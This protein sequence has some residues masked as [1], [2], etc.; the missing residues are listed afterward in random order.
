MAEIK[1]TLDLVM[2]K[3]RHLSFSE[4]E[5]QEQHSH[6]FAKRIK[7]LIQQYQDQKLRVENLKIELSDLRQTFGLKDRKSVV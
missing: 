6:E 1:S 3:T 5:K 2:E 7:G 4:Q